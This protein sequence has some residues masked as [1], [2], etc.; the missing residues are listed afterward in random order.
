MARSKYR[1]QKLAKNLS[2]CVS[3]QLRQY[4]QFEKKLVKQQY[5]LH[6]FWQYGELRPISGWDWFSCLEHPSKFQRVS[7]LGFFTAAT[8]LNGGQ[9]SFARCVAVSWA[10]TLYIHFR[11]LLPRD[12]ILPGAKFTLRP[13]LAFSYIAS[14]ILHGTP[15]AGVIQTLRRGIQG[16]EL[17]NFGRWRLYIRI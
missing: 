3:S 13:S 7:R 5:L 15:A 9:P 12:G 11:R 1:T 14:V 4:P 2:G 8:S 17:R 10:G 6:M 16:M